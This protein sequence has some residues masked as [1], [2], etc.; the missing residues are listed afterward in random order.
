MYLGSIFCFVYFLNIFDFLN[1]R[2]FSPGDLW[3]FLVALAHGAACWAVTLLHSVDIW[4]NAFHIICHHGQLTKGII[5]GSRSF[6]WPVSYPHRPLLHSVEIWSKPFHAAKLLQTYIVEMWWNPALCTRWFN[7]S[8]CWSAMLLAS[9]QWHAVE[10]QL[11]HIYFTNENGH[12]K[13]Y[14]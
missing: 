14:W 3:T 11:N 2:P 7:R 4:S 9:I 8:I 6:N 12:C 10:I 13:K 5:W 1:I